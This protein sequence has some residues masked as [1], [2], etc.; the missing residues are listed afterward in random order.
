MK[1]Q[2]RFGVFETN[3]S[4]VNT[5]MIMSAKEY[6][7]FMK[8]WYDQDWV[9]DRYADCWVYYEDRLND[10]YRYSPNPCVTSDWNYYDKETATYTTEHGDE[11]VAVSIYGYN[12]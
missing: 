6:E 10:E 5:L 11:I 4:S 9:W 3:S 12:G 7:D 1:R 8:K 2:I